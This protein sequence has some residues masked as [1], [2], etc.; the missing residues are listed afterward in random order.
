MP[1]DLAE[2]SSIAASLEQITRRIGIMA[3]QANDEQEETVSSELFSV[4][5]ALQGATRR[6]G[7]VVASR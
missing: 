3:E 7:R 2:L 6:L 1:T 5:R 4:E